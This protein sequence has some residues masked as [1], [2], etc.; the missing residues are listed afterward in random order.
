GSRLGGWLRQSGLR[1]S[2]SGLLLLA[3]GCGLAGAMA[4]VT[5][6]LAPYV[7]VLAFA[8]PAAIP[9]G[10][11][12]WRRSA[13][14]RR[15]EELFPEALD[16][17]SR[18]VQ[19]GHA[20][21]AG[22]KMVADEMRDPVGPEFRATFDEQNF[23]LP[24][25]E[26]LHHLSKRVP[27]VDVRFFVT[28][29]LIQRETGGNLA[30]ILDNLA[31]VV[32]ERFTLQRQVRTHTAHGRFTGY[33]LIGLPAFLALAL[34][35]IQPDHMNLLFQDP[36]GQRLIVA[37]ITMQAIGWLWIRKVIHIEV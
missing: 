5:A 2:L 19:A 18:A 28:A 9:F 25:A 22:L 27:L 13:R 24:M 34:S 10:V 29:V 16:L 36:I 30:E 8:A 32:R 14:L 3:M 37:A 17:I 31:N 1:L 4:G 26:S 7:A 33:I 12:A 6:G 11:V 21:A 35:F 20:F 15:F 23:G